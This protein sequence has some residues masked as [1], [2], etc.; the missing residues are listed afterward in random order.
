MTANTTSDRYRG[1]YW[2]LN[3]QFGALALFGLGLALVATGV[4]MTL[5]GNVGVGLAMSVVGVAVSAS[6]LTC[7][8]LQRRWF[9]EIDDRSRAVTIST[10]RSTSTFP[11]DAV[12]FRIPQQASIFPSRVQYTQ[13]GSQHP[14]TLVALSQGQR[15]TPSQLTSFAECLQRNG[16]F[17]EWK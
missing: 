12:I 4:G 14:R 8:V 11:A 13:P 3:I 2:L 17:F 1:G 5:S 6:G 7:V 16:I 15:T 10:P 9:V